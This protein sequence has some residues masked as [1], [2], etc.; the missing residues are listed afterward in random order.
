MVEKGAR[1][2]VNLDPAELFARILALRPRGVFLFHN[3]PSGILTPS[4]EDLDLTHT[5]REISEKFGIQLLGH[6]IVSAQSEHWI[7]LP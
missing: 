1:T 6:W 3:H 5:I 7:T 2:H 4:Q